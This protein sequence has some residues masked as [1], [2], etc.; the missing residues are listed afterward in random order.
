MYTYRESVHLGVTAHSAAKVAYLV[1]ELKREWQGRQYDLL[2]RNCNH[3][4]DAFC[5]RLGVGRI[6]PWVNRIANAGDATAE[7]V[8]S[9]VNQFRQIQAGVTSASRTAYRF[10]VGG[11]V[12]AEAPQP[13]ADALNS[14]DPGAASKRWSPTCQWDQQKPP[15]ADPTSEL[16]DVH[17]EVH[18][19][20]VPRAEA[21]LEDWEG[22]T[23]AADYFEKGLHLLNRDPSDDGEGTRYNSFFTSAGDAAEALVE[24]AGGGSSSK[25]W[26]GRWRSKS[27]MASSRDDKAPPMTEASKFF[28]TR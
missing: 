3:F 19:V 17:E 27:I 24:P 2:K 5:Q 13:P 6:P 20:S 16:S 4:C 18:R 25:R 10:L 9:S 26:S 15:A 14:Q 21:V 12:P 7:A 11:D 8:G 23:T 22:D 28:A 1:V